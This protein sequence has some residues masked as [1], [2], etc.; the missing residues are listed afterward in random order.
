MEKAG[1]TTNKFIAGLV[2]AIL[3]SSAV[4]VGISTQIIKNMY[5]L[6]DYDS[7]WVDITNNVGEYFNVTHNLNSEDIIVDIKGKTTVSGGA[8]QGYYGLTG[9][10]GRT[11]P[12][13][14]A[15]CDHAYSMVQTSD[16]GYAIAVYTESYGAGFS[17]FW[18]VK[19]NVESGLVWTDSTANT[20]TLY[21]GAT[22]VQWNYVRVRIWKID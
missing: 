22:D 6:P 20:L 16:E 19:T 11:Q 21:R 14:V 5:A 15:N 9:K 13:G 12:Y 1:I 18:L 2:I 3:V 7:G 17:D 10:T 8:H 4:S